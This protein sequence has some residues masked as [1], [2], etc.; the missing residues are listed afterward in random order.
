MSI[1]AF[2]TLCSITISIDHVL[3]SVLA[4]IN[5]QIRENS[6]LGVF[7]IQI[8]Q[9]SLLME[10]MFLAQTQNFAQNGEIER[11]SFIGIPTS[12]QIPS[13]EVLL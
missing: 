3:I 13:Q 1:F 2:H 10:S 8:C 12:Y 5:V 7:A 11:I 4:I 6:S 9:F